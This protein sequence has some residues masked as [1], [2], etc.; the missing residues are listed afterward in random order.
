METTKVRVKYSQ[1]QTEE[2][3]PVGFETVYYK[4]YTEEDRV[5]EGWWTTIHGKAHFVEPETIPKGTFKDIVFIGKNGGGY[6]SDWFYKC[7]GKNIS[8]FFEKL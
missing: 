4:T 5:S 1:S 2:V 6:S 3:F 7:T 8:E